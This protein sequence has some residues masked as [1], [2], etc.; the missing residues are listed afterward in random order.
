MASQPRIASSEGWAGRAATTPRNPISTIGSPRAKRTSCMR[1]PG[2]APVNT[3][4]TSRPGSSPASRIIRSARSTI[5]T[6][7]PMLST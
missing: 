4:S 7:C 3:M 6:G 5:F 2:R 1:S